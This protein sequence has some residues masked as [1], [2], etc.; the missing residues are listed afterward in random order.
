MAGLHSKPAP[1]IDDNMP[2]G[3]GAHTSHNTR[4]MS[5]KNIASLRNNADRVEECSDVKGCAIWIN[6]IGYSQVY[7]PITDIT[8]CEPKSTGQ[9]G[10][11]P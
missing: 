10:L 2:F 9:G 7:I 6:G 1:S 3:G 4:E 11:L 5:R 8:R